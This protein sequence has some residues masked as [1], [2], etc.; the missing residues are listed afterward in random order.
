MDNQKQVPSD[1]IDLGVLFSKIGDFFKSIGMGF[2]KG[3]ATLRVI[4][5]Q[6]KVLF[7]SLFSISILVAV[8]YSKGVV[9]K[10]Y[11]E[12]TMIINSDYLNTRILNETIEK[13]NLL[14][15]EK[16][17]TGLAKTLNIDKKL[18]D[19]ISSFN[20][21]PFLTQEE[22]IE[23]EILSERLKNLSEKKDVKLIDQIVGQ[24]Q[25]ENRHSFEIT[26]R[27]NSPLTI[28]KLETALLKYFRNDPFIKKRMEI[29]SI[30][31]LAKKRKLVSESEKLDSLK[32]V[33][34]QN[35]QSMAQQSRQGSNNVIL[36]DKAVTDPIQ[37]YNQDLEIYKEI[38]L[39]D[40][41]IY[42]KPAFEVVTGF[43]EFTEPAS[44]SLTKSIAIAILIAFALGYVIVALVNFNKYLSTLA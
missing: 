8:L 20:A 16:S 35:Y 30:N 13:L 23:L 5:I 34:F 41:D 29:D 37:I 42:I 12:S 21:K 44:P 38:Q 6:N 24:L 27:V 19:S 15:D 32:K 11:Y 28:N 40:R 26:V 7:I 4:P 36:S 33:I 10:K 31:L 18:A 2:L 3:L 25:V 43:T 9:S 14:A 39:I 1:E 17:K 22:V